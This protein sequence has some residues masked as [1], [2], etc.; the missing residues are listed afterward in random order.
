MNPPFSSPTSD[1]IVKDGWV[2]GVEKTASPNFDQR[3]ADVIVDTIVIHGISLPPASF[4]GNFVEALFTNRLNTAEHQYFAEIAGLKVSAHFYIN[5]A[6]RIRQFV[7]IHDRAWHAGVSFFYGRERVN[8]FSIG[9]ELEGTDDVAY[10]DAQYGSLA[11]LLANLLIDNPALSIE[12]ICGHCD[13]AAGRKTD[14]GSSFE[15]P[16][17][18]SLLVAQLNGRVAV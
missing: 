11:G 15:W 12:R 6:G 8:D 4:G 9:I 16:R 2:V 7:S 10:D 3:P 17:L 14:P 5:R 1:P 13:I 18:R